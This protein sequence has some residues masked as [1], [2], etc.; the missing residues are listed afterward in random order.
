MKIGFAPGPTG[1]IAMPAGAV[2]AGIDK[3]PVT[4]KASNP[5]RAKERNFGIIVFLQKSKTIMAPRP[6][7]KEIMHIEPYRMNGA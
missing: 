7:R 2:A 3:Q 4:P 6:V 5:E 1:P